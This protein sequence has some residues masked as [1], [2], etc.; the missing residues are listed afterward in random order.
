LHITIAYTSLTDI[1]YNYWL[2]L[3]FEGEQHVGEQHHR[4]HHR[5]RGRRQRLQPQLRFKLAAQR[6]EFNERKSA[7]GFCCQKA[8]WVQDMFCNFYLVK[9]AKIKPQ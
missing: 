7:A 4:L 5:Q 9:I 6:G 2:A 3:L 1:V 8:A